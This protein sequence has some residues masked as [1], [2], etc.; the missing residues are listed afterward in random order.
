MPS[1]TA[2]RSRAARDRRVRRGNGRRAARPAGR[3]RPP[4]RQVISCRKNDSLGTTGRPIDGR[5]SAA[6]MRSR[7]SR[8]SR[9]PRRPPAGPP[10]AKPSTPQANRGRAPGRPPPPPDRR[11]ARDA[12]AAARADIAARADRNHPMRPPPRRTRHRTGDTWRRTA[13][14]DLPTCS[15]SGGRSTVLTL[16]GLLPRWVRRGHGQSGP[17]T[18]FAPPTRRSTPVDPQ[19]RE[20]LTADRDSRVGVVLD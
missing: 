17:F 11:R 8:R 13:N 3:E 10:P 20:E 7:P 1:C 9:R 12:A 16:V 4:C 15:S 19:E 18:V 2:A 6:T 14:R 5:Y